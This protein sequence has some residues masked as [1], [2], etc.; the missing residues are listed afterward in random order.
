MDTVDI[1]N[2]NAKGPGRAVAFRVVTEYICRSYIFEGWTMALFHQIRRKDENET[3][4]EMV[5][6]YGKPAGPSTQD[7]R[8]QEEIE[9]AVQKRGRKPDP[10][11][12]QLLT[13]RLD[14]QVIEHFRATGDG[15]QTRMNMALRK[16]AGL[17]ET[18]RS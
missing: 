8:Q 18:S 5:R 9:K 16:A 13:L 14:P 17:T 4:K 15:W 1:V 2:P 7:K 10:N 12:K 3:L 6:L 11:A